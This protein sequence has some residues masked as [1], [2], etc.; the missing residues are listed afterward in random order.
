MQL[1]VNILYLLFLSLSLLSSLRERCLLLCLSE[2]RCLLR[3]SGERDRAIY[4]VFFLLKA[5]KGKERKTKK[6]V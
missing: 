2:E 6:K 1:C 3:L 5:N 4:F